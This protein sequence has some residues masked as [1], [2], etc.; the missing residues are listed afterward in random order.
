MFGC[1]AG[2]VWPQMQEPDR[3]RIQSK[4]GCR[5]EAGKRTTKTIPHE[6]ITIK[7]ELTPRHNYAWKPDRWRQDAENHTGTGTH[8]GKQKGM[9]KYYKP[10]THRGYNK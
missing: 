4:H 6:T 1:V 7:Q 9:T 10:K 5:A 8:L 2:R 3:I